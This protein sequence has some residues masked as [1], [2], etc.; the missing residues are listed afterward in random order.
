MLNFKKIESE[1][2]DL[3]LIAIHCCV[4]IFAIYLAVFDY[5]FYLDAETAIYPGCC[6]FLALSVWLFFSWYLFTKNLFHPYTIFLLAAILFNGGQ[7][8]LEVFDFNDHGILEGKFSSEILVKTILFIILALSFFHL[9]A[10]IGGLPEKSI[11]S[12][13]YLETKKLQ[14]KQ[15]ATYII[16]WIFI[17]ISFFP[18][19]F[20]LREAFTVVHSQGYE[21]SYQ[22]EIATS[23]NAAPHILSSFL[24]PGAIFM[25]TG[26]T[27]KMKHKIVGAVL[28]LAYSFGFFSL[29][30]RHEATMPLVALAWFWNYYI[31]KIPKF[32]LFG[33]SSVLL[34]IVFPF[35]AVNRSA[36]GADRTSLEYLLDNFTSIDNPAVKSIAEIGSSMMTVSYVMELVP[37]ERDFQWGA[38]Y[39]YA[40]LTLIPNFF[41][42]IHPT[43]ARG[44]AGNWLT[45]EII[46]YNAY[47]GGGLGF[48]FLA[49]AYLNFGWWGAPL[50][51]VMGFLFSKL[52]LWAT[53]TKKDTAKIALIASFTS[54]FPFYARAESVSI[55]RGLAWYCLVPYLGVYI[56]MS[57]LK[58]TKNV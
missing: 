50:L 45:W 31:Q 8:I 41:G 27:K 36:A 48:S 6:L 52:T 58:S 24:V 5:L 32:F 17:A 3:I 56:L 39:F 51:G 22:Q 28:I 30:K 55:V 34:F 7:L 14:V 35:I 43:I 13:N 15:R 38:D 16:G 19:L 12:L 18:F 20:V 33:V 53:K 46:P 44:L 21:A 42:E 54:F 57:H 9:G 23:F 4:V 40:F 26:S 49:E 25:M 29:G 10:L 11:S 1:R 2:Q 47:R 37:R